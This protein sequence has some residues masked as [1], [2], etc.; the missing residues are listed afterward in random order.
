[1]MEDAEMD[2]VEDA[3]NLDDDGI[4]RLVALIP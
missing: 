4:V 2:G 1:M 3:I